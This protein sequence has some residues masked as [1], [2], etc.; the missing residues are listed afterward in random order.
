MGLIYSIVRFMISVT[1]MAR[2]ALTAHAFKLAAPL[3]LVIVGSADITRGI[4]RNI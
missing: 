2:T 4:A 1:K 3:S